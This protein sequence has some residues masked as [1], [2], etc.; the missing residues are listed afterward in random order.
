MNTNMNIFKLT[1]MGE[2]EYENDYSDWYSQIQIQL[3]ILLRKKGE[4]NNKYII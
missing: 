4:K 3:P 1:E 2:Y